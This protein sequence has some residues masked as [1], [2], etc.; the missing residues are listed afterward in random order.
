MSSQEQLPIVDC[1]FG[2][3]PP[4][5]QAALPADSA[6]FLYAA[7]SRILP[8]LHNRPDVG[9]HPLRG[10]LIGKRSMLLPKRS[11]LTFRA[12]AGLVGPLL[13][14]AG[15]TLTVA[16]VP[17]QVGTPNIYPLAPAALLSSRLV[18]IRGF[19]EPDAFLA[20]VQRQLEKMGVG[21][22]A[23]LVTRQSPTAVETDGKGGQGE[24]IR[25]TLRVKDMEI[26]GF[27][28]EVGGLSAADSLRLQEVGLGGRRKF[29]CGVLVP[30][31]TSR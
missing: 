22:Q 27:A 9:I 5:S 19:Q 18:I 20:A 4:S 16:G 26:V 1:S 8:W 28:V 13:A 10:R 6:Y 14:L 21:G 3:F 23:R 25:R 15:K 29:G 11:T 12:P 24:W 31:R 17:L 2:L 30:K 7:I